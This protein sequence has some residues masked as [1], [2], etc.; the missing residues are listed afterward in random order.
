MNLLN[1]ISQ[2]LDIVCQITTKCATVPKS[3]FFRELN[4]AL[5]SRIN[6]VV[7]IEDFPWLLT[8]MCRTVAYKAWHQQQ[9][10]LIIPGSACLGNVHYCRCAAVFRPI[11]RHQAHADRNKPRHL[12][13]ILW[14]LNIFR[15]HINQLVLD[16][17]QIWCLDVFC[18]TAKRQGSS[19]SSVLEAPLLVHHE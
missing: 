9:Q 18:F 14:I 17:G 10:Q 11:H 16:R 8:G 7:E 4:T 12:M 15:S 19:G 1:L 2:W 3:K 5:E 6:F 13:R